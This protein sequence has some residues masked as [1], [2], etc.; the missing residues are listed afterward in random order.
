MYRLLRRIVT[1]SSLPLEDDWDAIHN[2]D[3]GGKTFLDVS[4]FMRKNHF[5]A[6]AL[7]VVKTSVDVEKGGSKKKIGTKLMT[8]NMVKESLTPSLE[9]ARNYLN[10]F[11]YGLL[12]HNLWISDLGKGLAS[13]G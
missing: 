10:F 11:C 1:K 12:S 9:A 6:A 8:S 7:R 13:C 3:F 2:F 5:R 4:D